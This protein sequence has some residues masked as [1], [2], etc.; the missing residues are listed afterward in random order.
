MKTVLDNMEF[1]TNELA[2]AAFVTNAVNTGSD[3]ADT[4]LLIHF[5]GTDGATTYT[6]ETGQTVTFVGT[7]Q[8]DTA[9]KE[10]GTASL[11]LD[12]NSDYVTVPDS[13]DWDFGSG[14]FTI[15]FWVRFN[16]SVTECH[17]G[18]W[19]ADDR[20]W[21][22][23]INND[24]DTVL[25]IYSTDGSNQVVVPQWTYSSFGQ[26]IWYHIAC[27][28]SGTT[29]MLFVDG[30]KQAEKT[31]NATIYDSTRVLT[32]GASLVDTS[33][34]NGWIDEPRISKVMI[35]PANFTPQ[36]F[37]YMPLQCGSEAIIKTQGSYSL[38]SKSGKT[39]SLNKTLTRTV[40]PTIDLSGI[41]QA[42][43][44]IRSSRT[45][46]NIKIGLHNNTEIVD[47]Q[48]A[49]LDRSSAIYGES[50]DHERIATRIQVSTAISCSKIALSLSKN[51]NPTDN[52]VIRI[53]TSSS[54]LPSGILVDANAT[55]SVSA[56][57]VSGWAFLDFTFPAV[58]N[59]AA[60][61]DY[62]IVI[63]RSGARDETN[64]LF[65]AI[66][67]VTGGFYA[68]TTRD[69]TWATLNTS[70]SLN[71]KIYK[72]TTT[73]ITPNILSANTWQEVKINLQN[74]LNANKDAID[75]IIITIMDATAANTFYIDNLFGYYIA[76]VVNIG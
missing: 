3:D 31:L 38:L 59:L 23:H 75:Q 52:V 15:D 28:R 54:N 60:A 58:F 4:K 35:W 40:S 33:Y 24:G 34:L 47:S 74:V 12:G 69:T 9:Q 55:T 42:K 51:G 44:D 48:V 25:F 66:G 32:I 63:S 73:E 30:V 71:Y 41:N 5:D 6:A 68:Y 65:S 11:L 49:S 70:G 2:Q 67:D 7:A 62:F 26:G 18:Q 21:K 72:R 19:G 56:T 53:E 10:F 37:N 61:T 43:F 29:L 14:N 27:V 22:F 46:S 45:G 13:A 64:Y 39:T 76:P 36:T 17:I 16:A 20:G 57:L 1:S 8:L 50:G